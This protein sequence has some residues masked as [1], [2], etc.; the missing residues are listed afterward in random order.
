MGPSAPYS[1]QAGP[2]HT[3]VWEAH[4]S[5]VSVSGRDLAAIPASVSL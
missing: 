3:H 2:P 4:Q 5:A 1:Q